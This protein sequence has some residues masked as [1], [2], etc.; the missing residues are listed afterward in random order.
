VAHKITTYIL[1]LIIAVAFAALPAIGQENTL[2]LHADQSL[3]DNGFL[4]HLL[5]RFSLKHGV[6][7]Q[8]VPENEAAQISL[9]PDAARIAVFAEDARV[10]FLSTLREGENVDAVETFS[11]WLTSEIGQNTVSGF[12]LDGQAVYGQVVVAVVEII[13]TV[14]SGSAENGAL[15]SLQKCGRCH[16]V[17]PENRMAGIGSTPSFALLRSLGDWEERFLTFYTRIPHPSFT[18]L[19]DV[20]P[21]FPANLPSP[22]VPIELTLDELE[23]LLTFISEMAPADLGDALQFQ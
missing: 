10:Y 14:F 9:F 4:R 23:D 20:T 8:V 19:T 15:V 11:N 6:R 7:I 13:P 2:R 16:V 22:I 5:P 17:G 18:Q 3:V 21:P 12:T 1:S